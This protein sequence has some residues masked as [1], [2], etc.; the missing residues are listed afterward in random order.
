MRRLQTISLCFA[1]LG[2]LSAPLLM[3]SCAAIA[4]AP[5]QDL[6]ALA[7][8]TSC[9]APYIFRVDKAVQTDD[10][11]LDVYYTTRA[12]ALGFGAVTLST[13]AVCVDR[14]VRAYDVAS[15]EGGEPTSSIFYAQAL[16]SA[17]I[18]ADST[19]T[20][21]PTYTQIYQPPLTLGG[22]GRVIQVVNGETCG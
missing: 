3:T 9:D 13:K 5:P 2:I 14:N 21:T 20:C 7:A 16:T 6:Q 8:G 18:K 10:S 1:K 4:K 19:I 15:L 12:E 11:K 17:Q 22:S